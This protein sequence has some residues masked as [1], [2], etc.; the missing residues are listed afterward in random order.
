MRTP[1]PR[2]L[3]VLATVTALLLLPVAA[4]AYAPIGDDF[5]TCVTNQPSPGAAAEC[6]AGLFDPGTDV[7]VT[8]DLDPNDDESPDPDDIFTA[9]LTADADGVVTWRFTVPASI[10]DG[11]VLDIDAAGLFGGVP[12]VLSVPLTVVAFTESFITCDPE[13]TI[14]TGTVT[15]EAGFYDA[16]TT[17]NVRVANRLFDGTVTAGP[18]G[19]IQFSFTVPEDHPTGV[20]YVVTT[21]GNQNG[22]TLVLTFRGRIEADADGDGLPDTGADAGLLLGAALLAVLVGGG[23]LL[24]GRRRTDRASVDA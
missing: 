5:I 11:T 10:A 6:R 12:K 15:C 17:V 14:P 19:T 1:L 20:P 16:G 8:I 3:T 4:F 7:V 23:L 13:V 18:D 21:R 2:A 9:T 24:A 22:D